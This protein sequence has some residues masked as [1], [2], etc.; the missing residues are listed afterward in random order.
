MLYSGDKVR[1]I[2]VKVHLLQA[3]QNSFA[4]EKVGED[5]LQQTDCITHLVNASSDWRIFLNSPKIC[6]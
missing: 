2:S 6:A 3:R 1:I 5:G 4:E